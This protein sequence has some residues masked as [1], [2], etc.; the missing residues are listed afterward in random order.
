MEVPPPLCGVEAVATGAAADDED[1]EGSTQLD[2]V[3]STQGA[4]DDDQA[5]SELEAA[6]VWWIDIRVQHDPT[7]CSSS[8]LTV[9][10]HQLLTSVGVAA[11][12]EVADSVAAADEL[13]LDSAAVV[14]ASAEGR[15]LQTAPSARFL[16]TFFCPGL[17]EESRRVILY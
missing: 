1:D 11:G 3:A 4:L 13:E 15:I 8:P 9:S 5:D 16:I 17:L 12:V 2:D 10:A 7:T 6:G 14:A